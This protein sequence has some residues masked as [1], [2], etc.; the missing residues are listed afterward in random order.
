VTHGEDR[1]KIDQL[2]REVAATGMSRRQMIQRAGVLGISGAA[3]TMAFVAKAQLAVAQGADI[4][5]GVDPEAPLDIVVFK[6]GYGDDYAIN[7]KDMYQ[8]RFPD[9]EIAYIGTQRLQE[10]FQ[11]RVVDGNPPDVM[12]NG[13]AGSFNVTTLYNEGQLAPLDDLMTSP[14]YGLDG[15]NFL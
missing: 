11:P 6:G 2:F 4:P 9:S 13:G 3:L 5:L 8:E 7:V 15:I 12:L 14:S 1:R 10:Q